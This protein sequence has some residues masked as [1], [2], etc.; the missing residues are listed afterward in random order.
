MAIKGALRPKTADLIRV[1]RKVV[2]AC[3]EGGVEKKGGQ[4]ASPAR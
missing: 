3:L 4:G 1:R 2:M